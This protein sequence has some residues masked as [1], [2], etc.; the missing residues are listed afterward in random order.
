MFL[1]PG[2]E[3]FLFVQL[4]GFTELIEHRPQGNIS[5]QVMRARFVTHTTTRLA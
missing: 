4:G 2:K 3:N 5:W 1:Y